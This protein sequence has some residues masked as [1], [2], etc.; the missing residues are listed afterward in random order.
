VSRPRQIPVLIVGA[1]PA[2]LTAAIA[3]ARYGVECLLIERR[4][5]LSSLPRA[6]A[7]STRSMEILRGWGLED[8][9]R[10]GGTEVEWRQWFCETLAAAAKGNGYS[11]PTGL[12]TRSE[13]ALLSPSPPACVPQD[14]LE[15]VM[16][17]H[18]RSLPAAQ[19]ELG[20][21]V[22]AIEDDESSI[23]V[24]LRD[25]SGTRAVEAAHL[26]AADGVRS[27]VREALGISMHGEDDLLDAVSVLFRAP[28]W[29]SSATI[30]TGYTR[31]CTPSPAAS[32]C[33]PAAATA[34]STRRWVAP[35]RILA[36]C[37]RPTSSPRSAPAPAS[38]TSSP[39]LSGSAA[40]PSPPSS[41]SASAAGT[42][43]WSG[44]P[45]T[46]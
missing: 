13:A 3:L 46:R 14:H 35:A 36:A 10:A 18:L 24:I 44:T 27:V 1:G 40:S 32:S 28:L 21:E 38:P 33:P 19:V 34:G 9:I 39:G 7:I 8:E 41:P 31:R 43:S 11:S 5:A 30:D 2:G 26:I 23:R 4:P 29:A 37:E 15:P 45:P 22:V 6:T 20:T 12:P 25:E 16:L 17:R 42:R